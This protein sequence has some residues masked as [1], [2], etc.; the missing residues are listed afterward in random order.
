MNELFDLFIK[1]GLS[2]HIWAKNPVV[3]ERLFGPRVHNRLLANFLPDTLIFFVFRVF[4]PEGLNSYSDVD[5]TFNHRF[6]DWFCERYSF[7]V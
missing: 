7:K 6:I 1:Y 4:G 3:G 5:L 2:A